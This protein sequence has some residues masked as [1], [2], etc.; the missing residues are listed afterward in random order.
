M[1]CCHHS[2]IWVE[3]FHR[4][5]NYAHPVLQKN[6]ITQYSV[7]QLGTINIYIQTLQVSTTHYSTMC[8]FY[9]KQI[10]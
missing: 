1:V 4:C 3:W 8:F 5:M 10:T 7:Y 2:T 9:V 6:I